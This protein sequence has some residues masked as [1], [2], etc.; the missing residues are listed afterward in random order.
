MRTYIHTYIHSI[1][2][3][4]NN[5]NATYLCLSKDDLIDRYGGTL[6]CMHVC[7]YVCM[8]LSVNV[9]MYLCLFDV[10]II[11]NYIQS[12]LMYMHAM[13]MYAMCTYAMYMYAMYMYSMCMYA[14][15]V[16]AMFRGG[17][18]DRVHEL[19]PNDPDLRNPLQ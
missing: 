14:T 5:T 2:W 6:A 7:M 1:V 18:R 3:E 19:S 4:I 11:H 8:Y 15:Y 13:C 12:C 9:C 16:Y 10:C 17:M